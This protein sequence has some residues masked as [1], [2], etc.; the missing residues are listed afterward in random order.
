MYFAPEDSLTDHL[1]L[2][3]NDMILKGWIDN[4]Y[5]CIVE[6]IIFIIMIIIPIA[7]LLIIIKLLCLC[8]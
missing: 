8:S 3:E 1:P 4:L 6:I 5:L 7:I 2:C